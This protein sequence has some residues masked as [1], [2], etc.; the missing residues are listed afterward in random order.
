MPN[1]VIS[2]YQGADVLGGEEV[3]VAEL[4]AQGKPLYLNF[5][6]ALCPPC[7]AEMPDIQKVYEVYGDDVTMVG[8]DLGPFQLL[9]SREEGK[10]L[11][12]E[13][14]VSYPAGT[15]FDVDAVRELRILGMPTSLFI[16]T[17]GELQRRWTGF[18]TEDKLGEFIE[19]LLAES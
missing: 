10:E 4:L 14:E 17:N 19:E 6:A 3:T 11:L 12:V 16:T 7:R 1:F 18:L 2:T 5:W 8:V 9:G 13:L 15:T